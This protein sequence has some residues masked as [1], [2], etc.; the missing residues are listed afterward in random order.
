MGTSRTCLSRTSV[1]ATSPPTPRTTPVRSETVTLQ[2][3]I[4][5]PPISPASSRSFWRRSI[6]VPVRRWRTSPRRSSLVM[7][8]SSALSHQS[9]CASR[10]SPST[11]PSVASPSVTCVRPLPS[12]SSSRSTSPMPLARPPSLLP[13]PARNKLSCSC[14][15]KNAKHPPNPTNN[16]NS[17]LPWPFILL[18]ETP[19]SNIRNTF[20][21]SLSHYL[22]CG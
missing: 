7:P 4:A 6:A 12:V 2:S 22:Q 17:P 14:Y 10:P 9:P 1:V 13:R 19:P 3:W 5:T 15:F 18:F 16:K 21:N 8:P 11:H 20:E